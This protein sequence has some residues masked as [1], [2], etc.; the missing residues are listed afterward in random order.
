MDEL[1]HKR[2][3]NSKR[4]D[5]G[6]TRILADKREV[7]IYGEL[8]QNGLHDENPDGSFD[9]VNTLFED[10]DD[11]D[12]TDRVK[13]TRC[14]GISISNKL[15]QSKDSIKILTKNGNGIRL[16]LKGYKT[17][18]PHFDDLKSCYYTT[19][20]GYIL[21]YY[22]HYKGVNLVIEI[23]NPQTSAN[24]FR[25]I[26]REIGCDY[27]Y[28]E[29]SDGIRC[30]SSTGVDDIHIASSVVTDANGDY[31]PVNIKLGELTAE[32]YQILRKVIGPIWLGNAIGP[33]RM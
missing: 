17:Y 5:T 14:G 15:D 29:T 21:R 32:G 25:F 9:E 3:W 27:T 10:A 11:G 23:P 20:E 16:K 31:G 2:D 22:P 26:C 13:R 6:R 19:N 30:I 33:V 24:V 28:E 1:I 8:L 7:P 12:E 4:F 18:G